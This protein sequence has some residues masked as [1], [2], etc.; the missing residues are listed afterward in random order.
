[1]KPINPTPK[2]TV[3]MSVY[4]GEGYLKESIES[5][6]NQTFDD[7]EFIII[8]DGCTDGSLSII[9]QYA[10]K[11]TRIIILENHHRIHLT[12][13]LNKGLA[14]AKGEYIL[15]CDDDNELPEDFIA[16]HLINIKLY[17][18][19]VSCGVSIEEGIEKTPEG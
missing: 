16:K 4:N 8:N 1:M 6:L 7:F 12:K 10:R 3:L 5:I 11:D 19:S 2:I 17:N 18:K 15:F 13:S 14:I 9:E